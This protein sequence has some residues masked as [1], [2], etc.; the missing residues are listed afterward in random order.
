[1]VAPRVVSAEQSESQFKKTPEFGFEGAQG[2][3]N[4]DYLSLSG[5]RWVESAQILPEEFFK[6]NGLKF[7]KDRKRRRSVFRVAKQ[8]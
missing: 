4:A 3:D 1:M 7:R 6:S 2:F 5:T 8:A